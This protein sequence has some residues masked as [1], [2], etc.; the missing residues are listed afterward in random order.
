MFGCGAVAQ[1]TLSGG[2][3]GMFLT[4]N[5][6]F[7]FAATL[8]ILV[9]GQVSG[10]IRHKLLKAVNFFI[11]LLWEH[12]KFKKSDVAF[13]CSESQTAPEPDIKMWKPLPKHSPHR[14]TLVKLHNILIYF[15]NILFADI[16]GCLKLKCMDLLFLQVIQ[17]Q[18][19]S[20]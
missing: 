2:S 10:N 11:L 18:L 9:C 17:L 14:F 7:G 5:F 8:G 20:K 6:A 1:H 15:Q 19:W 3:H 4:V 12:R 13:Y 16:K